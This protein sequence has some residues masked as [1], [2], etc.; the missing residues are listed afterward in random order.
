MS[1]ATGVKQQN[2]EYQ[3]LGITRGCANHDH[4]LVHELSRR[5]DGVWRYDQYIANADGMADLQS[6]WQAV[7]NQEQEN[8]DRLKRLIAQH[9][10]RD[11]F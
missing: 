11:C 2:Q 7:K 1:L 8:I 5:L 10:K 3:H 4:D 6:F 9:V